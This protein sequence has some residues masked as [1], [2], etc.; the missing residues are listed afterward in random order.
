MDNVTPQTEIVEVPV[1]VLPEGH[2]HVGLGYVEHGG[3]ILRLSDGKPAWMQ[4]SGCWGMFGLVACQAALTGWDWLKQQGVGKV[5]EYEG[6]RYAIERGGGPAP[7][8]HLVCLDTGVHWFIRD[9]WPRL[10]D[11]MSDA[12]CR[13]RCQAIGEKP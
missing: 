3:Y 4:A 7:D 11:G 9:G 2:D 10:S 1:P 13:E 8:T 5:F 6:G 12:T